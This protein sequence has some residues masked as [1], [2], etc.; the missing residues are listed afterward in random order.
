MLLTV[1]PVVIANVI[2]DS[3]VVVVVVVDVVNSFF[4]P[5]VLLLLCCMHCLFRFIIYIKSIS[6]TDDYYFNDLVF[7]FVLCIRIDGTGF[8]FLTGI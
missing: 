4:L 8:G 5:V 7:K 3:F 6:E 1:L 2:L